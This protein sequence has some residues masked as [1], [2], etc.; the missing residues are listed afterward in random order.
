MAW[1]WGEKNQSELGKELV[2]PSNVQCTNYFL[3]M[4]VIISLLFLVFRN[5]EMDG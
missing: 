5:P 3:I 2:R 4:E 1:L